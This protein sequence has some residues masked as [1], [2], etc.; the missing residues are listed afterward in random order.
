[1][2]TGAR[3]RR[4]GVMQNDL[5]AVSVALLPSAERGHPLRDLR[6]LLYTASQ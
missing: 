3:T 1:M 6:V 2:V 4:D 5:F